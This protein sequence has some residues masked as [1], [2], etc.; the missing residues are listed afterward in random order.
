MSAERQWY[1]DVIC[2]NLALCIAGICK[3][4]IIAAPPWNEETFNIAM[5]NVK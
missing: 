2:K 1:P 5:V 3:A 4:Y